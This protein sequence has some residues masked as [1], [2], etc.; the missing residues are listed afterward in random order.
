MHKHMFIRNRQM[1]FREEAAGG[2]DIGVQEG[3]VN[4]A[5][6]SPVGK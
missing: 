1:V 4:E 6:A 5:S 3:L 2:G